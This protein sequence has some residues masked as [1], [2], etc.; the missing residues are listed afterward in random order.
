MLESDIGTVYLVGAGPGDAGLLTMRGAELIG[1]AE[2]LVYDALVNPE[3]LRLAPDTTEVIYGGKRSKDHAIPQGDLN[4]L[5]VDKAKEGKTVVRLKGGDPYLFGR[6]GEEAQ[7]LSQAGVPFEVV[8]GISSFCAAPNYAGIPVTHR[9]HCSSFT[10]LTGHED[11]TKDESSIDWKNLAENPG[12]KVVL[13]GVERIKRIADQLTANGL[14]ADTPVCMVR[15]GTRGKQESIDGT[16]ATIAS[17]VEAKQFKSPAVTVIGGV[18]GLREELNWFEKRPL[19]GK[20]IVITRTRKQASQLSRQL[21]ELGAEIMEIPTIRT[22]APSDP[23]RIV[24]AIMGLNSYSWI[25]F[26]SPNGVDWFFDYFFKAFDDLRDLGGARIAAVGPAT[27]AKLKAMHLK[28]DVMPDKYVTSEVAQA[29]NAFESVEHLNILLARAEVANPDLPKELEELRAI[30]DDIPC[31]Q[32]VPETDDANGAAARMTDEGADWITFTSSSTVENFHTRFD[33]PDLV[34]TYPEIK[35]ASIGPETSRAIRALDLEPT[36]EA[37]E[38]TIKGL[39][40]AL[41]EANAD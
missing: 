40:E 14:S 25:V 36:I 27:A 33:L 5:L 29:I 24:D 2:V 26:T 8:P 11:P 22:V 9:D 28:I 16:L 35:L 34:E 37:Q 17:I 3:M 41:S 20:R 21:A 1:R 23:K 18:V 30:V 31:Y 15:W 7:E 38:H 6:G 39:I 19:L 4:Q 12:T 32:T 13:M 10:V